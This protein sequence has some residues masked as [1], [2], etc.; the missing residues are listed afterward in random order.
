MYIM[1]FHT[2]THTHTITQGA[3]LVVS[4]TLWHISCHVSFEEKRV[5]KEKNKKTPKIYKPFTS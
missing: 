2:H 4:L 1:F 5:R 3:R